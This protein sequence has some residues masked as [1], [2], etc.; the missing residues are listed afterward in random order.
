MIYLKLFE[1]VRVDAM[2]LNKSF[3]ETALHVE[4]NKVD[5]RN[6]FKYCYQFIKASP[7]KDFLLNIR[8]F[9]YLCSTEDINESNEVV[10]LFNLLF[11]KKSS[12]VKF[13]LIENYALMKE[14]LRVAEK[15]GH[16]DVR[17]NYKDFLYRYLFQLILNKWQNDFDNEDLFKSIIKLRGHGIVKND[18]KILEY[19]R[20]NFVF[21]DMFDTFKKVTEE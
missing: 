14:T 19:L 17:F 21:E 10:R 3:N 4:D 8:H 12:I 5:K 20:D 9:P 11:E 1:L 7:E 6:Y 15:R 16:S 18:E 13:P 2:N